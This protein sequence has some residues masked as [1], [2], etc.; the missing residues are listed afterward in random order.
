[1]QHGLLQRDPRLGQPLGGQLQDLQN[2]PP[3]TRENFGRVPDSTQA[4]CTAQYNLF[5]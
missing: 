3:S 4:R 5:S 1:V 2:T